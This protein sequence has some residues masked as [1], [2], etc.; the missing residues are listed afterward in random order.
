MRW[1]AVWL[2]RRDEPRTPAQVAGVL[3]LAAV[4]VRDY[5]HCWNA[6]GPNGL[7]D[8]HKGNGAEPLLGE[9]QRAALCEA[10]KV[11]VAGKR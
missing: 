10:F 1:H 8:R 6:Q 3:G 11:L 2:L 4:T 7:L 9:G 5:L